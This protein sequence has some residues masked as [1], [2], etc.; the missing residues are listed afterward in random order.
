MKKE[1]ERL[2][3]NVKDLEWQLN[4]LRNDTADKK[5]KMEQELQEERA[6]VHNAQASIENDVDKQ[7]KKVMEEHERSIEELKKMHEQSMKESLK[8]VYSE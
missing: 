7:V 4:Q 5:R 1:N 8:K 3:L 2:T 6:K